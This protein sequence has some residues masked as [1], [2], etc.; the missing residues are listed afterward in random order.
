MVY[1]LKF[2]ASNAYRMKQLETAAILWGA[3]RALWKSITLGEAS[4]LPQTHIRE[5]A[6]C[7]NA[8]GDSEYDNAFRKGSHLPLDE[9][10]ELGIRGVL[11]AISDQSPLQ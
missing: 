11:T 6:A 1:M 7:R 3:E 9:S 10:I 8:M 4:L 5:A 2:C